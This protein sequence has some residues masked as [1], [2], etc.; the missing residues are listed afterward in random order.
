MLVPMTFIQTISDDEA[1]PELAELYEADRATHGQVANYTRAF[2][3]RPDVYR[4]WQQLN[5]AIK[6]NMDQRRYELAT[7]AAARRLRSSYCMLAHGAVL[8]TLEDESTVERIARDHR[9]AGLDDTDVAIMD[10]AEQVAEDAT[11]IDQRQIDALK[12]HGLDD[13]EVLDVVLAASARCFF[14]SVLDGLG[15][16]PDE[17]FAGMEPELRDALTVGRPIAAA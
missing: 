1:E 12:A 13:A 16:Q 4:A 17:R 9:S 8:S 7:L 3:H 11:A 15:A 10:L 2:S 6:A 5:G 14:S